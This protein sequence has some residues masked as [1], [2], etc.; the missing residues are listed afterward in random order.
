M[1]V[2]EAEARVP[3]LG[4]HYCKATLGGTWTRNPNT[5]T[6]NT[7]RNIISDF[8]IPSGVTLKVIGGGH[9]QITTGHITNL[10]TINNFGGIITISNSQDGI[11]IYNRSGGTI[12]NSGTINVSN[13]PVSPNVNYGLLNE[14]GGTITNS[15]TFTIDNSYGLGIYI[16]GGTF[17]NSGGTVTVNTPSGVYGINNFGTFDGSASI[18]SHY[19]AGNAITN[20]ASS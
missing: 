7:S 8:A 14:T 20:C 16:S 12:I 19:C 4:G 2:P 3:S 1:P 17:T 9:L 6:I 18:G 5:C 11:S 15:G 10:G 13:D